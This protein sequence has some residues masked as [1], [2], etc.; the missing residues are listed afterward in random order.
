LQPF[1]LQARDN[2]FQNALP[3]AIKYGDGRRPKKGF[4]LIEIA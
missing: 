4:A 3:A 2:C 1:I